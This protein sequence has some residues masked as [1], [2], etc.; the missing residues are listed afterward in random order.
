MQAEQEIADL[1]ARLQDLMEKLK[2]SKQM[3]PAMPTTFNEACELFGL[4]SHVTLAEFKAA[5][6]KLLQ[7]YHED[8]CRHLG[9]KLQQQAKIETQRINTAWEIVKKRFKK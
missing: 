3:P 6:L 2:R 7:Q 1:K 8:K 5:R 9:K 4:P